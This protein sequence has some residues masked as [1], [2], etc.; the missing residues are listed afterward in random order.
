LLTFDDGPVPGVTEGVLERLQAARARAV[1]FVVGQTAAQAPH[2][3]RTITDAGHAVGNHSWSHPGQA[4]PAPGGYL[5]DMRRCGDFIQTTTG[6]PCRLFRAP[7]GR[8]HPASLLGPGRQGMRHVLWSLDSNDWSSRHADDARRA[9]D[10]VLAEVRDGDIILLHDFSPL[11]HDL[12][13]VLLPGLQ[14][15]GFDL[16]AGLSRLTGP[17]PR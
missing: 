11:V 12:L 8:L 10:R 16:S 2:L 6:R 15:Q 5:A 7:E 3:L 1:F 13:D 17:G 9:A 14:G 4:W